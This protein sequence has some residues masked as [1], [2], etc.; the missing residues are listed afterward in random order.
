MLNADFTQKRKFI[1]KIGKMLHKY[2]T[3]A[4]RLEAHLAELTKTTD[5][6]EL[7]RKRAVVEAALAR[8]RARRQSP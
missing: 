5:E 6:D 8:A 7:A 1:V 4:Y 2:G 3:P